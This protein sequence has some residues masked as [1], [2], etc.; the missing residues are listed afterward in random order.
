MGI[1]VEDTPGAPRTEAERRR[2]EEPPG[3]MESAGPSAGG[4]EDGTGYGRLSV[5]RSVRGARTDRLTRTLGTPHRD[6]VRPGPNPSVLVRRFLFHSHFRRPGQSV[7]QFAAELK[8]L[9]DQCG[10]GSALDDALRDRLVCGLEEEALQRR[11]LEE[12]GP[13]SFDRAL[14]ISLEMEAAG[15]VRDLHNGT[16]TGTGRRAVAV[17]HVVRDVDHLL[18]VKDKVPHEQIWNPGLDQKDSEPTPI[19]EEKEASWS[20]VEGGRLR[21]VMQ[22]IPVLDSLADLEQLWALKHHVPPEQKDPRLSLDQDQEDPDPPGIEEE[23]ETLYTVKDR[24]QD[25]SPILVL[26]CPADMQQLWAVNEDVPPEQD[27]RPGLDQDQVRPGPAL[28]E[29]QEEPWTGPSLKDADMDCG[30]LAPPHLEDSGGPAP[31][32]RGLGGGPRLGCS[33]GLR[34]H[35]MAHSAEDGHVSSFSHAHHVT[36]Y[37]H[38]HT[39]EK[40]YGCSAGENSLRPKIYL[41][42]CLINETGEPNFVCSVCDKIFVSRKNLNDHRRVHAEGKPYAC[43]VCGHGFYVKSSVNRHMMSH[44]EGKLY[45]CTECGK[46]FPTKAEL[47]GHSRS[48]IGEK[49]YC[50]FE[51]GLRFSKA[52]SLRRHMM[53]HT[54]EKP[55]SCSICEKRF[56]QAVHL[57]VHMTKFHRSKKKVQV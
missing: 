23:P 31:P 54:G 20:R 6:P 9:S 28:I 42:K 37:P 7:A 17:L 18:V 53:L 25:Q 16:G 56:R 43:P 12:D 49:P 36:S 40:P 11:L 30:G 21:C 55:Y 46:K 48:H 34:S 19:K 44:T 51:C 22:H 45:A 5:R 57:N 38:V 50:C 39:L 2:A 41:R 14:D 32:H 33:N 13:L 4:A 15:H 10:F 52:Y 1:G 29:E 24:E 26:E 8:H 47:T 3:R 27:P 35:M